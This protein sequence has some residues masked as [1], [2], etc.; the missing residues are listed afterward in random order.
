MFKEASFDRSVI[1]LLVT[2]SP[3]LGV[4]MPPYTK[5]PLG[6]SFAIKCVC[7]CECVL[8]SKGRSGRTGE[9]MCILWYSE[10]L[11]LKKAFG[12]VEQKV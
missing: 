5:C 3:F 7:V 8:N 2:L 10:K 1:F 12:V 6:K 11:L 9:A 4:F